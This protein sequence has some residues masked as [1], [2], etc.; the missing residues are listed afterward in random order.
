MTPNQTTNKKKKRLFFSFPDNLK[1]WKEQNE[2]NNILNL[3][4]A[5]WPIFTQHLKLFYFPFPSY[6]II[7]HHCSLSSSNTMLFF[8]FS[9]HF[10]FIHRFNRSDITVERHQYQMN[11]PSRNDNNITFDFT[12]RIRKQIK[13]YLNASWIMR[14][15]EYVQMGN[16]RIQF[17]D[18]LLENLFV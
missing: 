14:V 7:L 15:S 13:I 9:C 8:I 12:F 6:T 18:R 1:N 5:V 3:V 16:K 11:E 2:K 17:F 10:W 4:T